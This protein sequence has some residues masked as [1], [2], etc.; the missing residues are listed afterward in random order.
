MEEI[1]TKLLEAAEIISFEQD[2]IDNTLLTFIPKSAD[3]ETAAITAPSIDSAVRELL[4]QN[5]G[6][7]DDTTRENFLNPPELDEELQLQTID[8]PYFFEFKTDLER[9]IRKSIDAVRSGVCV[10]IS[11]KIEFTVD[12]INAPEFAN[13][14]KLLQPLD[15]SITTTAKS[16]I[17]KLKGKINEFIA[18]NVDGRLLLLNP[19]CQ[20]SLDEMIEEAEEQVDEETNEKPETEPVDTEEADSE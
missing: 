1:L 17:S 8:H 2:E 15:Y 9:E 7:L 11:A 6:L 13:D 12:S 3:G 19:D 18:K 20:I 10:T 16:E 4:V 14:A 5:T